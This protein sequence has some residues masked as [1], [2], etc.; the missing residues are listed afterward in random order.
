MSYATHFSQV[1]E[2]ARRKRE[3]RP[4]LRWAG[5]KQPFLLRL[6][7]LLPHFSGNYIEPFLG[8]G[9]VFFYLQRSQRRAFSAILGDT[10]L[11]LIRTF[12]AVRERPFDV[13]KKLEELQNLYESAENKS[14]F[15]GVV[16]RSYN[17]QLPRVDPAEFIFLNRT[18]WNGLYRVN[19]RGEFNV[20]YGN[21]KSVKVTPSTDDLL[22][23]AAALTEAQIQAT[24][25]ENTLASAD[26]GDFVFLDPPYY[27]DL[28]ASS[29]KYGRDG[30]SLR[31]H[32]S[33][34]AHL[35]TLDRRGI[36]FVLTNSAEPEMME[37]Y[38]SHRLE[39]FT[40]LIPRFIS[41]K[42]DQRQPVN[43]IVVSNCLTPDPTQMSLPYAGEEELDS[44]GTVEELSSSF[45]VSDRCLD[46]DQDD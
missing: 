42:T 28:K 9:A 8:S 13:S 11:Q 41:S 7:H 15:F 16:R 46:V 18:C 26:E 31:D 4:F 20:P 33:L 40:A 19:Q 37:L 35:T 25:W 34:A 22:N 21:P 6:G 17:S 29:V 39:F 44:L 43:E 27:S 3:S 2:W 5:G 45:N 32:H 24:A 30:F 38:K 12:V 23:C 1:T 14:D 36:K 10:N